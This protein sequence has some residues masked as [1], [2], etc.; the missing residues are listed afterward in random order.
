MRE[1]SYYVFEWSKSS[2]FIH[3]RT[4]PKTFALAEV[5]ELSSDPARSLIKIVRIIAEL[6]FPF[7]TSN[8]LE[9]DNRSIFIDLS[10]AKHYSMKA[11]WK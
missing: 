8:M 4:T 1:K 3:N 11:I 10:V 6:M 9:V 7:E 5:E 2:L